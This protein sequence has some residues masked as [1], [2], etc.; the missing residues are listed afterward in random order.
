MSSSGKQEQ[1][2]VIEDGELIQYNG[3][4]GDVVIPDH[5]VEIDFYVFRCR[6]DLVSVTLPQG[7]R[8]IGAEAFR[9][10]ENLKEVK[11]SEN[12]L[13]ESQVNLI[14]PDDAWI[15]D[16]AFFDCG[17]LT[18]V[19]IPKGITGI[20]T[21]VFMNCPKL[22]SLTIPE[23]VTFIDHNAFKNVAPISFGKAE[24]GADCDREIGEGG[25]FISISVGFFQEPTKPTI[26]GSPGSYAEQFAKEK[27][28]IFK[29]I[30]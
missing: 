28:M 13:P 29:E 27:G 5:V 1:D 17:N 26:Y 3:P 8:Y 14:P 4:G 18:T 12:E 2:F 10:C 24:D 25:P 20:D 7:L 30:Q 23:T 11:V 16:A 22:S 6:D 21:A 9:G 19:V 15:V